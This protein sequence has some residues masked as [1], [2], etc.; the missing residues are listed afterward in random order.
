[1]VWYWVEEMVYS[2][3]RQGGCGQD[4]RNQNAFF[5]AYGGMIAL[6][7]PGWLQGA[8]ST[9]VGLF[10][11]MGMSTNIGKTVG[12][13]CRPCQAVGTQSEATYERRITGAGL[14]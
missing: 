9:L 10:D 12:M 1:M 14:S 2:A 7:D 5:Y 6:S 4:G 11:W 3:D 8:F 13:I